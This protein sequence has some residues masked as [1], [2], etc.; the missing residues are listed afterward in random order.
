MEIGS[1]Q[2]SR[3]ETR[4]VFSRPWGIMVNLHFLDSLQ[5]QAFFPNGHGDPQASL[6]VFETI[7]RD[8]GC[9]SWKLHLV[10]QDKN[11]GEEH[12]VKEA[13]KRSKV[14]LIG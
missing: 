5:S 11:V 3:F 1:S 9:S 14:R 13:W 7:S 12:L 4:Q 8:P 6:I 2:V 10:E